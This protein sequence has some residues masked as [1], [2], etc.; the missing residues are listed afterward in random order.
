MK[1]IMEQIG[2]HVDNIRHFFI[3]TWE[4]IKRLVIWFPIIWETRDWDYGYLLEMME[5][6]MKRMYDALTGDSAMGIQ[7]EDN[8]LALKRCINIL[9]LLQEDRW[10]EATF[11]EH[12]K[13]FPMKSLE[14]MFEPSGDGT[15]HRMLPMTT[16]ERKSFRKAMKQSEKDHAK[17]VAEFGELFGKHYRTWW[18]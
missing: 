7:S 5:F 16:A 13:N 11:Q 17:L 8:M 1:K 18:D 14:E 4:S 15:H 12:Y 3:H 10:E 2:Y 9:Y 6:K